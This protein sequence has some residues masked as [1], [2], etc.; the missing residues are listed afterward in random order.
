MTRKP[1]TN[2]DE[3]ES[4]FYFS[5]LNSDD[6]KRWLREM[7]L[8]GK[9]YFRK[10]DELND[11]NEL[12]PSIV[13]E[14]T[15][16]EI[17]RFVR[18]LIISRWPNKISPAKRL[19]EEKKLIYKYRNTPLWVEEM[20]HEILDQIGV[21]CLSSTSTQQLLWAHY[22]DGH[23]GIGVELDPQVGLFTAAQRVVY[24]DQAPIINRLI[25]D[26]RVMLDKSMFT[27][28]S[29]WE[30]EREWRVIA[31]WGDEAR[32]K[33]YL[34]QHIVPP[35]IESFMRDQHGP[36]YYSIPPEAVRS[37]ILGSRISAENEGWIRSLIE[38][39]SRSIMVRRASITRD[40]VVSIE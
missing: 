25:D 16:K 4:F 40:G 21:F 20:L 39:A 18:E 35:A 6:R 8:D 34:E 3:P 28:S 36:G 37:V 10:R 31:R 13:F 9:V 7:L 1:E 32:I 17:R 5:A 15:D 19:L 30:Y 33:R 27:K 22:A 11:P 26:S 29:A 14:G 12:R 2:S 23:R 24:T 38:G